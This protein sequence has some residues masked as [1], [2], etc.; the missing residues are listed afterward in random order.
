MTKLQGRTWA[1]SHAGQFGPIKTLILLA[2][3]D[4]ADKR[5][6]GQLRMA[7]LAERTA[8][9]P[10]AL[11]DHVVFLEI[12]KVVKTSPIKGHSGA[13]GTFWFKLNF[14]RE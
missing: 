1:W 7:E 3:A 10:L 11:G 5:A 6:E 14:V 12:S 13:T 2:L 4:A 9:P 8:I